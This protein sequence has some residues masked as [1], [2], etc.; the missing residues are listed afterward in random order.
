MGMGLKSFLCV[1]G[2][3]AVA[4]GQNVVDCSAC[5]NAEATRSGVLACTCTVNINFLG[6]QRSGEA[7]L[8]TSE[9]GSELN[10]AVTWE[11]SVVHNG[12]V[13]SSDVITLEDVA[14]CN[15]EVSLQLREIRYSEE[16]TTFCPRLTVCGVIDSVSQCATIQRTPDTCHSRRS[17]TGCLADTSCLWC[18]MACLPRVGNVDR[19]NVCTAPIVLVEDLPTC[20]NTT[21]PACA[22]RTAF[23]SCISGGCLWSAGDNS[24]ADRPTPLPSPTPP[25]PTNSRPSEEKL[26]PTRDIEQVYGGGVA[27]PR[28]TE[29]GFKFNEYNSFGSAQEG[30][31]GVILLL[32][33]CLS[34][35][36]CSVMFGKT[37]QNRKFIQLREEKIQ[38]EKCA[39]EVQ[40][41]SMTT[42]GPN[43]FYSNNDDLAQCTI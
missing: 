6:L 38:P 29:E 13:A 7:Q 12:T 31:V 41:R 32:F 11:G 5:E 27:S 4:Q 17:C 30:I 2:V 21:Q 18:G 34:C 20:P 26:R 23:A 9:C 24:C 42:E 43:S 15:D 8:T 16:G 25:S 36:F 35:C 1:L 14:S 3:A 10:A 37:I 19:C 28:D 40:L 39:S 22:S 33:C